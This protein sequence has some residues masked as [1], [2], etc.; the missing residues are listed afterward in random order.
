MITVIGLLIVAGLVG[1]FLLGRGLRIQ[2]EALRVEIALARIEEVL[3]KDS[4]VP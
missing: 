2:V 3:G 1:L 4:P